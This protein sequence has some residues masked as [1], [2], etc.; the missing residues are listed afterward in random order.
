[1]YCGLSM[2]AQRRRAVGR[3]ALP[4]SP[5][6]TATVYCTLS[7]WLCGKSNTCSGR[8]ESNPNL[9]TTEQLHSVTRS[10]GVQ[11]I[12]AAARWTSRAVGQLRDEHYYFSSQCVRRLVRWDMGQWASH[13]GPRVRVHCTLQAASFRVSSDPG[14]VGPHL[15]SLTPL[16]SRY[17]SKKSPLSEFLFPSPPTPTKQ[18]TVTMVAQIQ[19]PAP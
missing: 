3:R 6:V 11:G 16:T 5:V 1:M 7:R 9:C 4:S 13:S 2:D 15:P 10:R 18:T 14:S 12:A 8:Q 17:I 19:K